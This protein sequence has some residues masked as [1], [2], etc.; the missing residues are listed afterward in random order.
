[1]AH[2]HLENL[3]SLKLGNDQKKKKETMIIGAGRPAG[4]SQLQVPV[5]H[6]HTPS[7]CIIS[8]HIMVLPPSAGTAAVPPYSLWLRA[9]ALTPCAQN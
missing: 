2:T 5:A 1:M 4:S 7:C 8:Y 6:T 3:E 9:L